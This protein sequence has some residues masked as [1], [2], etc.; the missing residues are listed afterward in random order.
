MRDSGQHTA[1][2]VLLWKRFK[3]GSQEAFS[4]IYFAHYRTLYNYGYNLFAD[5]DF[6]KDTLQEFFLDLW[7]DR[8][9]LADV[10]S[11]RFYLLV[12]IRRKILYNLKKHRREP[13]FSVD[14]EAENYTSAPSPE[15]DLILEETEQ[16]THSEL[17]KE[18]NRLPLRQKEAIYLKY[19]QD[20]SYPE[21]TEVM[22]LQYQTV[23]DLIYKGIKNLREK[24]KNRLFF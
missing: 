10:Q 16:H 5:R 3:E 22:Q 4:R 12:S 9:H 13:L 23:R 15:S 8:E 2:D 7:Q 11:V 17:T 14:D 6:L 18:L 1:D 19:F 24:L 21:I 20:L